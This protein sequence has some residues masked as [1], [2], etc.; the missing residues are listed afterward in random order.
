[1]P[2]TK[3]GFLLF[4]TAG[5]QAVPFGAGTLCLQ[6]PV[7]RLGIQNSGGG[8]ICDGSF[9]D[10]FGSVIAANPGVFPPGQSVFCQYLFREASLPGGTGLSDGHRFVVG[11]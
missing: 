4:S 10:D 8:G 2:A 6:T 1:V 3:N 5:A 11:P 9:K 7:F